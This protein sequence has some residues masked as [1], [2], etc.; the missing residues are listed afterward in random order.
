MADMV[1]RVTPETLERKAS[2]FTDIVRDIQQRF[3]K[4]ATISSKT[5]GY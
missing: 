1:L 5:K 3:D 4:I 2:E